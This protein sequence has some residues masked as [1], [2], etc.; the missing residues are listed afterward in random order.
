M[1]WSVQ[2]GAEIMFNNST[3]HPVV[4]QGLM[5]SLQKTPRNGSLSPPIYTPSWKK[6]TF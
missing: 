2:N 5:M 3:P 1:L 4:W 6:I